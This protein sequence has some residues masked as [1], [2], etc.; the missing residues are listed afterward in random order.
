M[1]GITMRS[2]LLHECCTVNWGESVNSFVLFDGRNLSLENEFFCWTRRRELTSS[3]AQ[4]YEQPFRPRLYMT[5]RAMHKSQHTV[6]NVT[7]L[8]R[9]Y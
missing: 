2:E 8:M 3:H 5:E 7:Q 9:K 4:N 6:N 1:Y